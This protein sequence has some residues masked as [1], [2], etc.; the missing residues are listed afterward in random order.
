ME[1]DILTYYNRGRE[2]GRLNGVGRL[3]FVR[4]HELLAR[5]LPHPPARVLDVGGAAGIHALPLVARG[6]DVT[7]LDPVPL[8]VDQ[9]R[10]AGVSSAL[11]GDA[12]D[13]PFAD[14]STD[15][16]LLLGPLYH[17]TDHDERVA[18][19]GEARRVTRRG[20]V[21]VAAVISRFASTYDGLGLGYLADPRFERIVDDDVATGQ[22]RNPTRQPGWFTTAYLHHPDEIG[23]ELA[24]SGWEPTALLAVE[25]TGAFAD[26][27]DW[28]D[29]PDRKRTLLRA[30]QR[31][32]AEPS[33]LG[34]SPH[35]LAVATRP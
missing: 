16:T 21:L 5:F 1:P 25:G 8:H 3:E 29:D 23:Q 2:A 22:H 11:L 24:E 14:A 26:A 17:L 27:A 32:E 7:L 12:R 4:T 35:L 15:A 33:L 10:T 9:A 6:Y 31:V 18:A 13:L 19:L 30:V 20:G 28:L 34:A